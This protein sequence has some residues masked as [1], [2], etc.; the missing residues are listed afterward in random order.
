MNYE[1]IECEE[2]IIVGLSAVT[3]NGDPEMGSI[4]GG[5]WGKLYEGG[6]MA[7]IKN[8]AD[9]YA[10]GLYSD[11]TDDKYQV[12]V[13]ATVSSNDNPELSCKV[14]PAGKYAKFSVHGDQVK[15]VGAA[16]G[17]IWKM[18]L[19]RSFTGDYEV[20]LNSDCKNADVD[21]FIAL[22]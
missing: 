15:A 5:L 20:Y 16:W 3:G 21:I 1:I 14:L 22:K 10:I 2:K 18:D 6:V 13:G 11:Y 8:K 4:I 7:S 12:T 19:P 9:E 17:E